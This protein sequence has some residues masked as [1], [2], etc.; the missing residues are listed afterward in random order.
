V[1]GLFFG[2]VPFC[3]QG[4]EGIRIL[5]ANE[6]KTGYGV[7]LLL[8]VLPAVL[9]GAALIAWGIWLLVGACD[10]EIR[11]GKIATTERAG[12]FHWTRWR[13]VESIRRL[14]VKII[15]KWRSTKRF[16]GKEEIRIGPLSEVGILT[17]ECEDVKPLAV[18]GYPR[19]WLRAIADDL[20]VRLR[21]VTSTIR[22]P[23]QQA[24]VEVT[25]T[26]FNQSTDFRQLFPF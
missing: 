7:L 12:P 10:I 3:R 20:A 4:L 16:R 9:V 23:V 11:D 13:P 2:G 14:E 25:E 19:D 15:P 1:F 21:P 6:P 8:T 18:P 5:L 17:I 22:S 24:V 26:V